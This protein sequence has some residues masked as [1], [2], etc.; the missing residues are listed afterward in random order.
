VKNRINLDIINCR[1]E[2]AV[3][4]FNFAG[5]INGMYFL[6]TNWELCWAGGPGI[7]VVSENRKK[8]PLNFT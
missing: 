8:I 6:V 4:F 2:L 3:L 1:S 5:I 7:P